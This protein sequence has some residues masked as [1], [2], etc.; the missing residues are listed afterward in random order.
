LLATSPN[1]G[2]SRQKAHAPKIFLA[3]RPTT[4]FVVSIR[5]FPT[6]PKSEVARQDFSGIKKEGGKSKTSRRVVG[7]ISTA[8][9]RERGRIILLSRPWEAGRATK[10][11]SPDWPRTSKAS[12]Y[13]LHLLQRQRD[14]AHFIAFNGDFL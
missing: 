8:E 2:N 9:R 11:H 12:S 6:A 10:N 1:A 5:R 7:A 13:L 4:H 3:G 14:V